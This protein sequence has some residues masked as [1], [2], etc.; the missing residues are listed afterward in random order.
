MGVR[1]GKASGKN[2]DYIGQNVSIENI[3]TGKRTKKE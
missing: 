3:Q 1:W 2:V